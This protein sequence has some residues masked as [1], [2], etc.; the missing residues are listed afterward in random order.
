VLAD[1]KTGN[2]KG[3]K[4]DLATAFTLEKT[5]QEQQTHH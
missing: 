5:I 2:K 3:R 1:R 4:F